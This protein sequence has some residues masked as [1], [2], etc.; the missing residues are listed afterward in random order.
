MARLSLEVL[1]QL[2]WQ[3]VSFRY[4]VSVCCTYS[5][6]TSSLPCWWPF[7]L[8]EMTRCR[9]QPDELDQITVLAILDSQNLHML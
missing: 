3:N 9:M 8:H 6:C 4:E 7:Q 2:F 1:L 5:L